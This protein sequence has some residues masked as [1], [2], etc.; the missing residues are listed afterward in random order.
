VKA[1]LPPA[2]RTYHCDTCGVVV[3]RDANAAL[4]LLGLTAG[5]AG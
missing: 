1:K 2:E 3:D 4:N 5:L